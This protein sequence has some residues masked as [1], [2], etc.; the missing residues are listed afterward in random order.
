MGTDSLVFLIVSIKMP[1]PSE[2]LEKLM[3][4]A[5]YCEKS[6]NT[7]HHLYGDSTFSSNDCLWS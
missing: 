5:H 7:H 3:K 1:F 2:S 6:G 4:G